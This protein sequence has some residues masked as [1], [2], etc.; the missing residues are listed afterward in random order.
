M[1]G[2]S[3]AIGISFLK[4]VQGG[5][6]EV[7]EPDSTRHVFGDPDSDLHAA[8]EVHDRRFWRKMLGASVGLGEAYR[9]GIWDVDDPV[10]LTRIGARNL[11]ALDRWRRRFRPL[12]GSRTAPFAGC[13]GTESARP[14][15]TS[16]PTTT[17]ATT[18]S[19]SSSTSR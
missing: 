11:P 14:G 15:D 19:P 3:R 2:L 10:A 6:L 17:W 1:S 12:L 9:D 8:I 5:Y 4:R 13:P 7:T 18:C 16:P